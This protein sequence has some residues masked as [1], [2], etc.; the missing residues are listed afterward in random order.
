MSR[1]RDMCWY[2]A[3]W[4][5]FLSFIENVAHPPLCPPPFFFQPRPR[6]F[7][8]TVGPTS[9][10]D[11]SIATYGW[12]VLFRHSIST[13]NSA[14]RFSRWLNISHLPSGYSVI[15]GCDWH[16]VW[17]VDSCVQP[18]KFRFLAVNCQALTRNIYRIPFLSAVSDWTFSSVQ[19]Y[20]I[21]AR[22]NLWWRRCYSAQH[23]IN[24]ECFINFFSLKISGGRKL[25]Y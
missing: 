4:E 24:F 9:T 1:R 13:H 23:V 25:N 20:I 17:F 12:T 16:G 7:V 6:S 22:D 15:K 3:L 10:T 11:L 2:R 19:I 18:A 5:Y 14:S 21:L 8:L